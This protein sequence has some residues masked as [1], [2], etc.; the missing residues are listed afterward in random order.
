MG[1]GADICVMGALLS[2]LGVVRTVRTVTTT[3]SG[4]YDF[5]VEAGLL[6]YR[7]N[8]ETFLHKLDASCKLAEVLI[9]SL[10]TLRD[11]SEDLYGR[12]KTALVSLEY[13]NKILNQT[14]WRSDLHWKL[15][16]KS[17][18]MQ[19]LDDIYSDLKTALNSIKLEVDADNLNATHQT[20]QLKLKQWATTP[21]TKQQLKSIED[22]IKNAVQKSIELTEMSTSDAV[23]R[24]HVLQHFNTCGSWPVINTIDSLNPPQLQVVEGLGNKFIVSWSKS[25]DVDFFELC[26]DEDQ[27]LS[28]PLVGNVYKIELGS[29]KVEPGRIYT[30]K[31]RGINDKGKGKWSNPVV[32]KFT[33]PSPCKPSPP[34]LHMVSIS[35]AAITVVTPTLSCE[36]ESIVTEWNVRYVI[37]GQDKEW[38]TKNHKVESHQR[39]HTFYVQDLKPNQK[40]YFEVQAVNADGES[41]FSQPVCFKTDL[42]LSLDRPEIEVV[43][44]SK[45]KLTIQLP[46]QLPPVTE[47]EL[48]CTHEPPKPITYKGESEDEIQTFVLENLLPNQNYNIQ[49][50]AIL[51]GDYGTI[52]SPV[53]P[54]K[55]PCVDAPSFATLL[56]QLTLALSAMLTPLSL[57]YIIL[58]CQEYITYFGYYIIPC[59]IY[60]TPFIFYHF[61]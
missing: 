48:Q 50:R 22:K 43:G 31:I 40:Y 11:T 36:S 49:V 28:I 2:F 32:A 59:V 30:M 29:P 9:T 26:Y 42:K 41:N 5:L 54:F 18:E 46:T 57:Y 14:N 51:A 60:V 10:T 37:D 3:I 13:L 27:H 23:N 15:E 58:Y 24:L 4:G 12:V 47:W 1:R 61:M 44:V 20:F 33:K 16:W 52:I 21:Q 39:K 25:D 55:T 45:V 38:T 6:V 56:L 7:E 34:E 17:N 53:V 8:V 19:K 35:V